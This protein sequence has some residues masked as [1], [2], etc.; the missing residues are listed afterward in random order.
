[1]AS[2]DVCSSHGSIVYRIYL[3][4]LVNT[5]TV[6]TTPCSSELTLERCLRSVCSQLQHPFLFWSAEFLN[7]FWHEMCHCGCGY[8]NIVMGIFENK[9][10]GAE[11]IAQFANMCF[12]QKLGFETF[13]TSVDI[14]KINYACIFLFL[15]SLILE[16][17]TDL[18]GSK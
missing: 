9:I 5:Q 1:M 6:F 11:G 14:L 8:L 15:L 16:F 17:S 10:K 7:Q 12:M 3:N 2:Q 18:L 4:L 13:A